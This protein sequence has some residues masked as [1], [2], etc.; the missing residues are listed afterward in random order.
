MKWGV[1]TL[2]W[3]SIPSRGEGGGE[4]RGKR[5]GERG[6]E[7]VV[8]LLVASCYIETGISSSYVGKRFPHVVK[9][10]EAF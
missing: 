5:E 6:R 4:G 9:Y 1:V 3:T 7:G 2:Q 10:P 8:I